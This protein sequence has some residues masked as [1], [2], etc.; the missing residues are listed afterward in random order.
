MHDHGHRNRRGTAADSAADAN[1]NS[2][3]GQGAPGNRPGSPDEPEVEALGRTRDARYRLIV[4]M[5]EEGIW[6]VDRDWKTTYANRY[7]AELLGVTPD[8]MLGQSITAFMDTDGRAAVAALQSRREAGARETHEFRFV[9]ADGTDIW[10][11]VSTNP[12]LDASGAFDGALALIVDIT[13]RKQDEERLLMYQQ[14]VD[15]TPDSMALVGRDYRYR[16]VNDT[17]MRR[18]GRRRD[19]IVG[20]HIAEIMSEAVFEATIRP[21]LDR[22]LKGDTISYAEWF[23]FPAQG[24]RCYLEVTYFPCR[25]S[26][27]AVV[28]VVARTRDITERR[29]AEEALRASEATLDGALE[30]AQIGSYVWDLRDDSLTWSRHMY[31]VAGL[32]PEAVVDNLQTTIASMVHPDDRDRI[33]REVA[34]MV[35]QRRTWPMEFRFVRPDGQII[36]LRSGSRFEF[37]AEGRPIRNV[38]VHHEITERKQ[39][40]EALRQAHDELEHRVVERTSELIRSLDELAV[41]NEALAKAASLKDEFLATMSHELRT[42]LTGILGL[43]EV[44][45]LGIYGPIPERAQNALASID[46]SGRHLLNLINDI[47]DVEKIEAGK[48]ELELEPLDVNEL[49]LASLTMIKELAQPKRQHLAYQVKPVDLELVADPRRLKQ[50]LVNLL[51]N[52]VKFTPEKGH[53][54]LE[55]LADEAQQVVRFTVW[56]DGVGIAADDLQRLFKPFVQVDAR[57]AR[58]HTGTG[59]GLSLVLRLTELHG[60]S[61]AVESTPGAG[62]RFTVILPW[63][64]SDDGAA[65]AL[66]GE[67]K[68]ATTSGDQRDA[69]VLV[70]ED[71]PISLELLTDYLVNEGYRV[72]QARSGSEAV[73]LVEHQRPDLVIMDVQMPGTDGIAA[74]QQIRRLEDPILAVVPIIAVTALA[75]PGDRE[76]CLLA[77][78]D[79]YFSKPINLKML[80]N[81]IR[82]Y[83]NRPA[84]SITQ[85]INC[86]E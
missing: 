28:G 81:V 2:A 6:L 68:P 25:D 75:M 44:I 52:A 13:Q 45:R 30:I 85:T 32:A 55:V 11:L 37:D 21:H 49:C 29:Q 54:G 82:G 79:E 27:D 74:S 7:I 26:S 69:L 18:T 23:D 22:C 10:T 35:E 61:V 20:R 19:E 36:W 46:E 16:I 86:A 39:A 41:A 60:G 59:L 50:I 77:G 15:S 62:S 83:L 66:A 5:A 4:E 78:M 57:L 9:R 72:V 53:L 40:E 84:D 14:I 31:A 3:S 58:T 71:N 1:P 34:A 8:A 24:G 51:S 65:H 12:I 43:T 56:D 48:L 33:A 42:P 67:W 17:Y 73:N 70:A 38:G 63:L 64:R 47:L 80:V 76:R